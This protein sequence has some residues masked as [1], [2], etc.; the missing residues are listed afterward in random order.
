[1][2]NEITYFVSVNG[3]HEYNGSFDDCMAY[4]IEQTQNTENSLIDEDYTTLADGGDVHG[5]VIAELEEEETPEENEVDE[6]FENDDNAY[7]M[8]LSDSW[9][10]KYGN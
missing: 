3:E 9:D 6:E 1:M 5:Y 4:V 2:T 7:E 8:A 10:R